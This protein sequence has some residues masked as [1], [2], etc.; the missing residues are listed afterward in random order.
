MKSIRACHEISI[1]I[2]ARSI[3]SSNGYRARRRRSLIAIHRENL[4][5]T[6]HDIACGLW[7]I[8]LFIYILLYFFIYVTFVYLYFRLAYLRL[9]VVQRLEIDRN[10]ERTGE[11]VNF[12]VPFLNRGLAGKG[13]FYAS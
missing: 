1:Y 2:D 11:P 10:S 7:H 8:D 6:R 13:V 3:A 4:K 5:K 12:S 9:Y